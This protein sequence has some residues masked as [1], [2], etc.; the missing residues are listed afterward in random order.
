M[1]LLGSAIAVGCGSSSSPAP[2]GTSTPDGTGG[3]TSTNTLL[4]R[5]NGTYLLGCDLSDEDVPE[6]GY[7]TVTVVIAGETST[8]TLYSYTDAACTQPDVPAIIEITSSLNYPGG[9]VQTD[10]GVADFVDITAEN[11]TSDG[12]ALSDEQR[13]FF[14]ILGLFATNYDFFVLE[15]S[16]LYSGLLTDELTGESAATRPNALDPVVLIRQ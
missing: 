5:Y 15:G 13:Q 14:T 2:D 16:S 4:T 6:D 10:R 12:Q 7:E 9:T 1:V 8:A 3:D 11:I